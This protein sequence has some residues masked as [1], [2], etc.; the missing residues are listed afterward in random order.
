MTQTFLSAADIAAAQDLAF[1]DHVV[2]EW[3]NLPTRVQ[4][5][6]AADTIAFHKA[7]HDHGGYDDNGMFILLAF[8]LRNGAN[9]RILSVDDIPML[10][11]KNIN[12]MNRLQLIALRINKMD[13]EGKEALKKALSEAVSTVSPTA[14]PAV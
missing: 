8:A 12:V 5:L 11:K 1:E 9:E 3:G 6:G 4:E 10:L 13:T 14:S 2:P 7:M